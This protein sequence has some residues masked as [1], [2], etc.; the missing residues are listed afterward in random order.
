MIEYLPRFYEDIREARAIIDSDSDAVSELNVAIGDVLDQFHVDRAT[1]GLEIWERLVGLPSAA[2]YTIWDSMKNQSV[3][4]DTLEFKTWDLIERSYTSSLDER[5]AAVKSRLRGTGTVTKDML[6]SV[7]ASYT[8][9]TVD[10]NEFASE[11]RVQIVFTDI[12]GVPINMD[13]LQAVVRDIMP[14][15]LEIEYVYR[16]LRWTELDG[17]AWSWDTLD[18]KSYTWDEFSEAIQ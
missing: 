11:Y 6:K 13:A 4:F 8:G 1:W 18:G 10:I 2:K 7:C 17:Y 9:G 5:R 12:A 15:H 14:A 16:Y 3:L